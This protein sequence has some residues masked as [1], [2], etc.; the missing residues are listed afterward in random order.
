V[1]ANWREFKQN[2]EVK[3]NQLARLAKTKTAKPPLKKLP[4]GGMDPFENLDKNCPAK[5]IRR[6]WGHLVS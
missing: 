4:P 6:P 5:E 1:G 2:A 3:S